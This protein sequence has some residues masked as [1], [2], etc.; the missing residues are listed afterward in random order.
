SIRLYSLSMS[1]LSAFLR[2]ASSL[3][4][5]TVSQISF[6]SFELRKTVWYSQ[7]GGGSSSK[8]PISSISWFSC[9][10]LTTYRATVPNIS[11]TPPALVSAMVSRLKLRVAA[12]PAVERA[13]LVL[14]RLQPLA[15]LLRQVLSRPIDV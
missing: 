3:S 9:P 14:G 12:L 7:P 10:G 5:T 13:Q 2:Y 1:G 6:G 15:P 11:L 8:D 4:K